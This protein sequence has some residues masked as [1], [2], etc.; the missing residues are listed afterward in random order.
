MPEEPPA[1]TPLGARTIRLIGAV[2]QFGEPG[3]ADH[4]AWRKACS[5]RMGPAAP[6]C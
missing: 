5:I 3:R 2:D 6:I 1:D 4:K